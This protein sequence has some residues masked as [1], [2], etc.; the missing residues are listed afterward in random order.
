MTSVLNFKW[1]SV[2]HIQTW[3]KELKEYLIF[4][5]T[6]H[7]NKNYSAFLEKSLLPKLSKEK[8]DCV[9]QGTN[10]TWSVLILEHTAKQL[11]QCLPTQFSLNHPVNM[12]K[13]IHKSTRHKN[14][15]EN[16]TDNRTALTKRTR[17][18]LQETMVAL[19]H[20]SEN[21]SITL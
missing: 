6:S 18:L 15:P 9:L 2:K 13:C 19:R 21:K 5:L 1:G 4:F 16:N 20:K 3:G 14:M 11:P 12:G 17:V 10:K 7:E 8:F